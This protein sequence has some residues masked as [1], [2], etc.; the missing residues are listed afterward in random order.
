[1]SS[2]MGD[3]CR[4]QALVAAVFLSPRQVA[5]SPHAEP[6]VLDWDTPVKEDDGDP[7]LRALFTL[8]NLR[9]SDVVGTLPW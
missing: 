1:M 5:Q 7:Y 3:S 6:P 8:M 4:R 2:L 9:C